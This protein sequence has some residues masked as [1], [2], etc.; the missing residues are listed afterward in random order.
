MTDTEILKRY[1]WFLDDTIPKKIVAML[2]PHCSCDTDFPD[3]KT[4]ITT[5]NSDGNC[6]AQAALTKVKEQQ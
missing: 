5:G 1:E 4:V 6:I 2:Y 3:L